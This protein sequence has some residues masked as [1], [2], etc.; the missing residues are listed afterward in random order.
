VLSGNPNAI[1]LLENNQYNI[2]WAMLS[3]NPNASRLLENNQ[4]KIYWGVL[5]RNP[6]IFKID[7]YNMLQN[8]MLFAEELMLTVFAPIRL[9]KIAE[10]TNQSFMEVLNSY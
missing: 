6:C 3:G 4:D 10:K 8:C 5:Y 7:Q 1:H 9:N 2:N